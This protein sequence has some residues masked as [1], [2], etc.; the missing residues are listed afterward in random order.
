MSC[1]NI[2][3]TLIP[4]PTK[5]RSLPPQAGRVSIRSALQHKDSSILNGA[6]NTMLALYVLLR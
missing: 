4:P 5:L 1:L 2:I 3:D 6:Y